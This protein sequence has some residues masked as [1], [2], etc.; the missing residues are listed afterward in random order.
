MSTSLE[1]LSDYKK[2]EV[3]GNLASL[4][5]STDPDT[6]IYYATE[7]LKLSEELDYPEGLAKAYDFLGYL[8]KQKGLLNESATN[9]FYALKYYNELVNQERIAD[10]LNNLGNIFT[11]GFEYNNAIMY[12]KKS[13]EV[14]ENLHDDE[15]L[16]RAHFNLGRCLIRSGQ[17]D[18]SLQSFLFALELNK[19][20][21]DY[22]RINK[23]YNELGNLYYE[24][25]NP[26]E[27]LDNYLS[28]LNYIDS[29]RNNG[30]MRGMLYNNIGDIYLELENFEKAEFFLKEAL[31][32][33]KTLDDK[34]LLIS[35]Y[36]NLSEL[37]Y[38]LENR[39]LSVDYL[40][41]SI[42]IANRYIV[43]EELM[44]TLNSA[45]DIFS[46]F[47]DQFK[48]SEVFDFYQIQNDQLNL[49]AD[50]QKEL[51]ELN[52]RFMLQL[53]YEKYQ[54]AEAN[55]MLQNKLSKTIQIAIP[56]LVFILIVSLYYFKR[57]RTVKKFEAERNKRLNEIQKD[58]EIFISDYDILKQI[59]RQ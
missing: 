7:L 53:S 9:Y 25:K 44:I 47:P 19:K 3:L 17:Y 14:A 10:V 40:N 42:G 46:A 1:Y 30:R 22:S 24:W 41:K 23:T 13:I 29:V 34:D 54:M 16:S 21:K 50:L 55:S 33:K 38:Q 57:Y 26:E 8:F 12:Y 32:I 51:Q 56:I 27:A 37:Y 49:V 11:K 45:P 18:L 28:S 48:K 52:G 31:S 58:A 6:S 35:T 15:R 39:E 4:T 43:N 36:R 20:N 2:A 5:Y 59:T